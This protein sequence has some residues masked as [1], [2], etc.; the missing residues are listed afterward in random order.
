MIN[1][2]LAFNRYTTATKTIQ[3]YQQGHYDQTNNWVEDTWS[4]PIKFACTALPYGD[5]DSGVSG[6]KLEATDVGERYPAFMQIHSRK[7]M[8]MKSII[9]IYGLQY[10]VMQVSDISD[11]GFYRVI[12][13]KVLER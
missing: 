9:N 7:E 13:A 3:I 5:R 6:Q 10:K 8:P 4:A 12:A 1:Q 2:R 11:A